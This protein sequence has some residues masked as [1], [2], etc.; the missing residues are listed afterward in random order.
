[1][2]FT[3]TSAATTRGRTRSRSQSQFSGSRRS[4]ASSATWLERVAVVLLHVRAAM[5]GRLVA[6]ELVSVR[7]LVLVRA[8]TCFHRDT[9]PVTRPRHAR[10][11][12]LGALGL[13][14]F[15]QDLGRV[16]AD[17]G[18]SDT[19]GQGRT[20]RANALH[21]LQHAALAGRTAEV[22]RGGRRG[23]TACAR[24]GRSR[25]ARAA[26]ARAGRS[27]S[28]R[29]ACVRASTTHS[30]RASSGGRRTGSGFTRAARSTRL[31][32]ISCSCSSARLRTAGSASGHRIRI[33]R[34]STAH[35]CQR[36]DPRGPNTHPVIEPRIESARDDHAVGTPAAARFEA[37]T[38]SHS[39][40][41][42]R[43]AFLGCAGNPA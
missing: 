37:S 36:Q 24:A 29:A 3:F 7:A 38:R 14:A 43:D 1:M 13:H 6:H 42:S 23:L 9:R 2:S 19:R 35:E 34:R 22:A 41:I 18:G 11:L 32:A 27:R 26:C 16:A 40:R 15:A 31:A 33:F 25:S 8:R 5:S 30:R 10:H 12:P 4:H 21:F 39:I 28:A 17:G 20:G